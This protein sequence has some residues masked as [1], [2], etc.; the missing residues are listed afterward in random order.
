[1]VNHPRPKGKALLLGRSHS[2]GDGGGNVF[3]GDKAGA[4]CVLRGG[5]G[6]SRSAGSGV[7]FTQPAEAAA[8][9]AAVVSGARCRSR[10]CCPLRSSRAVPLRG[11]LPGRSRST[12]HGLGTGTRA[13]DAP[14]LRARCRSTGGHPATPALAGGRWGQE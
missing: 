1:M 11:E 13:G 14:H 5:V 7:T 3:F 12:P 10:A 2:L 6:R 8:T 4:G 9:V